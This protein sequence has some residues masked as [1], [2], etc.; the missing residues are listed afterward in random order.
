MF[1]R[2]LFQ[3]KLY[4]PF[5]LYSTTLLVRNNNLEKKRKKNN[6]YLN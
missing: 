3:S 1:T 6:K 5:N 2:N 4:M